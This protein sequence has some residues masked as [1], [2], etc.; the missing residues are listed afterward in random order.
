MEG[1]DFLLLLLKCLG[2]GTNSIFLV[3]NQNGV[4][5]FD[6]SEE[7][8]AIVLRSLFDATKCLRTSES[9]SCCICI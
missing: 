9:S 5:S 2:A 8:F 6:C 1:R 3:H 4:K 7:M